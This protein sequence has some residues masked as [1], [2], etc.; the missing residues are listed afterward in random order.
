MS[1][2]SKTQFMKITTNVCQLIYAKRHVR[3]G[4]DYGWSQSKNE[5]SRLSRNY[6]KIYAR[7]RKNERHERVRSRYNVRRLGGNRR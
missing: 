6:E 2:S 4:K 5:K 1:P 7:K 3:Y